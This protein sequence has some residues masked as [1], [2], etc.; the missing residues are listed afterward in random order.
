M[1]RWAAARSVPFIH[2][3]TDYVF[4]GRGS[5][6]WTE[7]DPAEPLS[8]YGASKL[9]GDQAIQAAGGCHL[10]LRTSWVYAA[11]G[12]NF[13]CTIARLAREQRELRVVDDQVGAPTPTSLLA[14][15]V[16]AIV[17]DD[18]DIDGLRARCTQAK[19]LVNLA[20]GGETTWHGFACAIVAGLR[21][22]GMP[23]AV[24][25]ITAVPTSKYLTKARRPQNSR[26]D[27]NRWRTVFAPAP[28]HWESALTSVLDEYLA[29]S[30]TEHAP[31]PEPRGNPSL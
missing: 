31:A 7:D 21:A 6:P 2:F 16:S 13:L 29:R 14:D 9:A 25:Q 3:S 28:A 11:Q 10:I 8:V 4:G 24:E 18:D 5:K 1:A 20:A 17:T 15:A 26:L 30:V 19:G 22:R 23:L 27:L 12:R